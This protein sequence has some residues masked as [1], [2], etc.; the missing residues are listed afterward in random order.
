MTWRNRIVIILQK[1]GL[2]GNILIFLTKRL[3]QV[4]TNNTLS[5]TKIVENGVPQGSVLSVSLFLIA[6]NDILDSVSNPVK[7]LLYADDL[8]LICRGT[9]PHIIQTLLQETLG[10][11]LNNTILKVTSSTKL[12]GLIFDRQLTWKTHLDKLRTDCNQRLNILKTIAANNWG[13]D[14]NTLLLPYK[15]I[16]RSKLD[17][18]SIVYNSANPSIL[19]KLNTISNTA[20]RLTVGAFRTSPINGILSEVSEPPLQT[21][22]KYLSVKYAIKT[23]SFPQ[24]PAYH[25][26]FKQNRTPR[27][28]SRKSRTP[29]PF[30]I[31]LD[32]YLKEL[33][34]EIHATTKR[35]NHSI[36]PWSAP[37]IESNTTLLEHNQKKKNHV[38]LK[39]LFQELKNNLPTHTQIY[40]DGSS[41]PTGSGY[42]VVS[43]QTIQKT[44]LHPKA[45]ALFCEINAKKH[46]MENISS[47]Q[48]KNFAIFCDSLNAITAIKNRWSNDSIIQE[49]QKAYKGATLRNNTIT[50]IWIPSHVEIVGNETADKATKEAANSSSSNIP[51]NNLPPETLNNILKSTIENKWNNVWKSSSSPRLRTLKDNFFKK[52]ISHTLPRHDQ[53]AV[54]RIILGH[55]KLTHKYLLNKE[56]PIC[57]TCNTPLT[58]EHIILHCQIYRWERQHYNIRPP[59]ENTL[60]NKEAIEKLLH[61][62]KQ[63]QLYHKL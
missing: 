2:K 5:T 36:P 16:I 20:L 42:A 18:G 56:P 62:L 55:T 37:E 3:I 10:L 7:G 40:T 44:K 1:H 48:D 8:T 19:K 35:A 33:N 39:T 4:R 23:A 52:S 28:Q 51:N 14:L 54:S 15:T 27:T 22:R 11:T 63:S 38:V 41:S 32:N 47:Q 29:L 34:L 50:I 43:G 46:A 24:N 30:Y 49:C 31:R 26:V 6:I 61:F 53:V 25:N 57:G 21:R 9:N 13:A 45:P 17:Y 60:K 58:V 59:L 12:L